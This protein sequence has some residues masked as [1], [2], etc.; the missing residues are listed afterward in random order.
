MTDQ[1]V[2]KITTYDPAKKREVTAGSVIGHTFYKKVDNYKHYCYK[3]KGYGIQ[4]DI[5]EKLL[6]LG[7]DT[8]Q[9]K[10]DKDII[11]SVRFA[12]W[13]TKGIAKDIGNGLQHFYPVAKMT[14]IY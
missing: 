14:R 1:V 10:T 6:K 11:Y 5:M 4:A 8:I 2:I 7:V 12:A 13:A 3:F 9:I